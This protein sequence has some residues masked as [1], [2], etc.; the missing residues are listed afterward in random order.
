MLVNAMK[1]V[2]L[3]DLKHAKTPVKSFSASPADAFTVPV[4]ICAAVVAAVV[5]VEPH[6]DQIQQSDTVYTLMHQ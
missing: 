1:T 2:I 5:V 4:S 3:N 6:N